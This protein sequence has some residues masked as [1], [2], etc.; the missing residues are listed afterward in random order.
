[1]ALFISHYLGNKIIYMFVY[2]KICRE[3]ATISMYVPTTKI[4]TTWLETEAENASR[5]RIRTFSRGL[6]EEMK[7]QFSATWNNK[8][9]LTAALIDPRNKYSPKLMT[10]SEWKQAEMYLI[11]ASKGNMKAYIFVVISSCSHPQSTVVDID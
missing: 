7:D 2:L 9:L 8:I 1:M 4:L 3:D 5:K 6:A 11:A 10:N